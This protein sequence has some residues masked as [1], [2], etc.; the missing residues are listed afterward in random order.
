MTQSDSDPSL[1]SPVGVGPEDHR[2]HRPAD[3]R[4]EVY[5]QGSPLLRGNIGKLFLL[6]LV[7]AV[8][9]VLP[10]FLHFGTDTHLPGLAWAAFILVGLLF[11][12]LPVLLQRTVRYRVSNY[13]IDFERGIF[14]KNIDTLEL[15]HVEDIKFHQSFFDR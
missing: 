3:D 11:I 9:I 14:G 10:I 1:D 2:P 13:R 6:V 15:W 5:Y 12:V 7:G 8:L 4:E